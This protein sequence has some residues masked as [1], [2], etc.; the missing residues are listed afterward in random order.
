[1][2][3][4]LHPG[5]KYRQQIRSTLSKYNSYFRKKTFMRYN[6]YLKRR[7]NQCHPGRRAGAKLTGAQWQ[8]PGLAV[9]DWALENQGQAPRTAL[10]ALMSL[11]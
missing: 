11:P 4:Q 7:Y 1:M 8:C 6:Q 10:E 3:T 5:L 9:T 2:F